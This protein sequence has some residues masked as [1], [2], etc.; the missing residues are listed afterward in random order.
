MNVASYTTAN[1]SAR[2]CSML[3]P[4]SV[5]LAIMTSELHHNNRTRSTVGEF[6]GESLID[7]L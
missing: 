6:S 1:P 7:S 5:T 4:R 2:Y 3:W